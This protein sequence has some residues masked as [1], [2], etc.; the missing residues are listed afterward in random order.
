MAVNHP[1]R[2]GGVMLC[3]GKSRRMGLPKA[4]LPFGAEA[5]ATRVARLLGDVV[6]PVVAVAAVAQELPTL[7]DGVQV[8]YD[9]REDRGPLEGLLAGLSALPPE[10]DAA[11]VTSCDVPLLAPAFVRRMIELLGDAEIAV[12]Y[13]DG[14]HH[15][16]AAVYRRSTVSAIE[17]LLAA[18]RMRPVFLFDAVATRVI[19]ADELT[20]VDPTLGTL[21]NLNRPADYFAALDA[22]G[23]PISTEIAA[24]LSARTDD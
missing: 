24:R 13:V 15:P 14:F 23:L 3:G 18:D 19:E 2:I 9:R 11:F 7:P 12:P 21:K 5:M 16:L 20:P 4:T 10:T 22:A 1:I 17:A 6:S 8:V